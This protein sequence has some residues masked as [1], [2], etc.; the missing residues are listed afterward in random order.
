MP[1]RERNVAI[2]IFHPTQI[3]RAKMVD[4]TSQLREVALIWGSRA[5]SLEKGVTELLKLAK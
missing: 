1:A 3:V 4:V 2:E 5:S